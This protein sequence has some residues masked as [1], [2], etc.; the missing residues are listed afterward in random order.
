MSLLT[1]F[2]MDVRILRHETCRTEN[3]DQRN[4]T[5]RKWWGVCAQIPNGTTTYWGSVN[6]ACTRYI[7]DP[8]ISVSIVSFAFHIQP[9]SRWTRN[10]LKSEM[11]YGNKRYNDS[12]NTS[13]TVWTHHYVNVVVLMD[14]VQKDELIKWMDSVRAFAAK[15]NSLELESKERIWD[16]YLFN[17]LVTD[18]LWPSI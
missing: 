10:T 12:S 2:G 5:L 9:S 17:I 13:G 15:F 11:V 3:T 4:K 18:S 16:W 7:M 8:K 1:Q 14:N 6:A